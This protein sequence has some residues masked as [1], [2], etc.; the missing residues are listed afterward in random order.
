[1]EMATQEQAWSSTAKQHLT[2]ALPFIYALRLTRKS[3]EDLR[4]RNALQQANLKVCKRLAVRLSVLD[5]PEEPSLIDEEMAS[6]IIN[7]NLYLVCHAPAIPTQP[8]H[9]IFWSAIGRL[10]AERIDV[11]GAAAEF[12]Q[13]LSCNSLQHMRQ[14]LD[15][16]TAGDADELLAQ[17]RQRLDLPKGPIPLPQ[18]RPIPVPD[19]APS[20][21]PSKKEQ[22]VPVDPGRTGTDP[23]TGT[24]TPTPPPPPARPQSRR[25]RIVRKKPAP[26]GSNNALQRT[27]EETT[28]EIVRLY[29]EN[30]GR[31]TLP[32]NHLQ[33]EETPRC[34]II[35]FSSEEIRD[36]VR[37]SQMLNPDDVVRFIEVKGRSSRTSLVELDRNQRA[38]ALEY[39]ER[40]Y[41]YRVYADRN[42]SS[43]FE[44]AVLPNPANAPAERTT[45]L[46]QYD[47]R[48]G[49][50]AE[51]F[52]LISEEEQ[53]K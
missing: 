23:P 41:L 7:D 33:G 10:L 22:S 18:E 34:D 9:I 14:L 30:A 45:T 36:S 17:A 44:L 5:G 3:D 39:R 20:G 26:G 21:E 52:E 19:A 6:L 38:G 37:T 8:T 53:D 49:S 50:G 42:D 51:W 46:Y 47:L 15:F 25:R 24:F 11:G 40:Y 1:D 48:E 13:L 32:V 12:A 35:S 43:H 4:E 29:E 2:S 28:L 16:M 31:F 27:D